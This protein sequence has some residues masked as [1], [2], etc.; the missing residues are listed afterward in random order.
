M[1]CGARVAA[2]EEPE[3]SA[4]PATSTVSADDVPSD[5]ASKAKEEASPR[6]AASP[7]TT[8]TAFDT[9]QRS[10]GMKSLA[11]WVIMAIII[12]PTIFISFLLLR[13]GS[14]QVILALQPTFTPLPPPPSLTPTWT[15]E[16]TETPVATETPIPSATPAPT[17]TPQPPRYHPVASGETLF[18]LSLFYRISPD[19]IAE[20]NE[21]PINS[22][23]QVGQQLV[24]PWPTA[25]PPFGMARTRGRTDP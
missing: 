23:I 19:S 1:M 7:T 13:G 3:L 24:I 9:A 21:I 15:P 12:I 20:A 17:D 5:D 18:G 10:Q 2:P 8:V 14:S 22:P 4:G 25:T 11:L 6:K 16:A